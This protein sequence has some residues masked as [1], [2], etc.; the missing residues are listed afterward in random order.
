MQQLFKELQAIDSCTVQLS[1]DLS[2]K[3]RQVATLLYRPIIGSPALNTYFAMWSTAEVSKMSSLNHY[4]FMEMTGLSL[5]DFLQARITL[6]AIG[7][8]KTHKRDGQDLREFSYTVLAP[9]SGN[10]FFLEPILSTMLFRSTDEKVYRKLREF[11]QLESVKT[12]D[13]YED[14]S[15]NFHDVFTNKVDIHLQKELL[16]ADSD[17]LTEKKVGPAFDWTT[18]NF[19]LLFEGLK[20]Q[21]IP[22]N[23]IGIDQKMLIAKMAFLYNLNAIDMQKIVLM[24]INEDNRL[25]EELLVKNAADFYKLTVSTTPPKIQSVSAVKKASVPAPVSESKDEQLIAYFE[26]IP[27]IELLRDIANGKEPLPVDVELANSLVSTYGFSPGVVNALIQFVMIKAK[28]KLNRNYV[29]KIASHWQR[30]NIVTAA[31]AI[32]ISR[33]EH[34]QY[35]EWKNEASTKQTKFFHKNR[36]GREEIVPEWF[37]KAKQARKDKKAQPEDQVTDEYLEKRRKL[38]ADLGISEGQEK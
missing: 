15:R 32:E 11:F 34:D 24:S 8:L 1:T 5:S 37:E 29:M 18:F 10:Q 21:L 30:E 20:K 23:Y 14:V 38:M 31:Q 9:V 33:K 17:L 35:L 16:A 2:D 4:F 27:P 13:S 6:E 3:H 19:D 12:K 7:L 25:I 28:M 36:N 22:T 26:E